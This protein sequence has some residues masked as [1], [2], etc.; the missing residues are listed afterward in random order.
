[1]GIERRTIYNRTEPG[2]T[3]VSRVM[4]VRISQNLLVFD[5]WIYDGK[6]NLFESA[7]GVHMRDVS[8]GRMKPPQWIIDNGEQEPR[9]LLKKHC[10]ALSLIEIRTLLPFAE[11]SLSEREQKR[12]RTMT[13]KRKR[14]YLA[15]RLACKRLSRTLRGDDRHTAAPEITT[16]CAD[17]VHPC[18]MCTDGVSPLSCSASHDDRF[19]VAVASDGA[20][21]IDVEKVSDR[22]LKSQ[23]LYVSDK[24]RAL[25]EGS[26][27]GDIE[28]AVR[29]W[30]IKEAVAKALGITLAHSWNRVQVEAVG[31]NESRF[32]MG[33]KDFCTAV[34]SVIGQHVFTLVCGLSE[35]KKG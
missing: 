10:S 12:Y 3:Y 18:C 25:I 21:G 7:C 15:A 31:L 27:L 16:V 14:S 11:K 13:D 6:G 19:A 20:V 8:A 26:P 34:H 1:V 28:A 33:E 35:K 4:P 32:R 23:R 30:S 2:A 9:E 29:I 24:E 17:L 22:L 5:L